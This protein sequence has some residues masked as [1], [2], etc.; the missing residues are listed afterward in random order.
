MAGCDHAVG[1]RADDG[2]AGE[3]R[4]LGGLGARPAVLLLGFG[5]GRSGLVEIAL[6]RGAGGDQGF[7]TTDFAPGPVQTDL[8]GLGSGGG[9]SRFQPERFGVE[10]GEDLTLTDLIADIDV[11]SHDTTAGLRRHFMD[12]EGADRPDGREM[13][14]VRR[15]HSHRQS[16]L[17]R[18]H[19]R[20]R[21]R[22]AA[23]KEDRSA[24]DQG[25]KRQESRPRYK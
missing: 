9:A 3:A 12:S 24:R 8:G 14:A 22:R 10:L 11:K 1:G 15:P 7:Q 25:R 5:C 17:R 4:R 6:R 19:S 13:F 16:G 21:V 18:I 20:G 23:D 2:R